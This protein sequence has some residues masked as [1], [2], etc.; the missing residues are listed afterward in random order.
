[1]KNRTDND[2]SAQSGSTASGSTG[3]N[4]DAAGSAK[5]RAS[6]AYSST[7]DRTASAFSSGKDSVS[8]A[9]QRTAQRVETNP[10]A[11]VAGGLALGAIIAAILPRT[12]R[13]QEMLGDVGHKVTDVA[14]DAANSAVEAGRQQVNEITHNAMAQVGSAVVQAVASTDTSKSQ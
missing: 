1:M 10:V 12:Q 5:T 11:A 3:G 9:T 13:E 14:R 8:R 7:R 6:E 2:S 4:R